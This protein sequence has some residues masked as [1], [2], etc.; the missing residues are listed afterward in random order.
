MNERIDA[1]IKT[2]AQRICKHLYMFAYARGNVDSIFEI[3]RRSTDTR[4]EEYHIF[5][6]VEVNLDTESHG[7]KETFRMHLSLRSCHDDRDHKLK[8]HCAIFSPEVLHGEYVCEGILSII[9]TLKKTIRAKG[10]IFT[11]HSSIMQNT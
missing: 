2:A 8:L 9:H 11:R 7:Q 1:C 3:Q 5:D 10:V 4:K 6:V